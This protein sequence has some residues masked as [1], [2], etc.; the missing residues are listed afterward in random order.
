MLYLSNTAHN[1][2]MARKSHNTAIR[3]L[4]LISYQHLCLFLSFIPV[5]EKLSKHLLHYLS[6]TA[7]LVLFL[8]IIL[9]SNQQIQ[10]K[11]HSNSTEWHRKKVDHHAVCEHNL[12]KLLL[13]NGFILVECR[14]QRQDPETI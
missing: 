11:Y 1:S 6:V 4:Y 3:C 2:N 8:R 5:S 14:C 7:F 12:R 9:C 13:N 10:T